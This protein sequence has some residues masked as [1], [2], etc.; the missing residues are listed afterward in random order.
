MC[1]ERTANDLHADERVLCSWFWNVALSPL[2][3][4]PVQVRFRALDVLRTFEMV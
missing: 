4:S 2:A 3:A 1:E